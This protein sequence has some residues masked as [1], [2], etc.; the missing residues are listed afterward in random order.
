MIAGAAGA[1]MSG[2]KK[3]RKESL[4]G[5]L[6]D[7]AK[8][9]SKFLLLDPGEAAVVQYV[10]WKPA[11][12][13]RDPTKEVTIFEFRLDGIQKFWTNS[14]AKVMMALDSAN[15]GD[16]VKISREKMYTAAGVEVTGKTIW[17][18]ELLP[19]YDPKTGQT[20]APNAN[21]APQGSQ[22]PKKDPLEEAD[23]HLNHDFGDEV[24]PFATE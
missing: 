15:K 17:S 24:D 13:T 4:M 7:R 16:W 22:G 11:P 1:D 23:E 3:K 18:A 6:K 2:P 5:A 12:D 10:G 21:V 14:S 19:G 8:A 9:Q 20:M